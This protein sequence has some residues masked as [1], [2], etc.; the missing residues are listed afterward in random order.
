ML[1]RSPEEQNTNGEGTQKVGYTTD[2]ESIYKMGKQQVLSISSVQSFDPD[3]KTTKTE[4]KASKYGCGE[5]SCE[6]Q[7]CV[8]PHM[9]M[10][11]PAAIFSLM[12]AFDAT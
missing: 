5:A 4:K 2:R 6:K 12:E 1:Q 9:K 10:R 11:L 7:T 3:V 8:N